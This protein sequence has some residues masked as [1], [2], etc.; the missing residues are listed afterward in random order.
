MGVMSCSDI[1]YGALCKTCR[2]VGLSTGV[3]AQTI[4]AR[5]QKSNLSKAES[6]N[7]PSGVRQAAERGL[8]LRRQ[9]PRSSKAG[10]D[11]QQAGQQGIGSGV[12]RARDLISG[13]VSKETIK[14]MHAYFS[15]HA[16]NYKLD[17]GKKPH[18]DKGYVAGL[19]WGGE[20]GKSFAAK[21]T[22]RFQ[23]EERSEVE[24]SQLMEALGL[25]RLAASEQDIRVEPRV[26]A[27][28]DLS[29]A[30]TSKPSLKESL[31]E[32]YLITWLDSKTKECISEY[33]REASRKAGANMHRD[34]MNFGEIFTGAG[35]D[36]DPKLESVRDVV[37]SK[38]MKYAAMGHDENLVRAVNQDHVN[39]R[40]VNKIVRKCYR[41]YMGD[42][43]Q[44]TGNSQVGDY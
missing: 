16:S 29:K 20:A 19:L 39:K 2:Q 32:P 23:N 24:K 4:W 17:A 36:A 14:R 21:M 31:L 12:A 8:E 33:Q 13:K 43:P 42:L 38:L 11:T 26:S 34:Y 28:F 40:H 7:V 25:P 27:G 35:A 37:W 9:Q 44:P 6:Y 3:E 18:E 5:H 30:L 1:T 15:R 22:R 41:R 10:L